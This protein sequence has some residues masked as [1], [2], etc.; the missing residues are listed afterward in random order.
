MVRGDLAAGLAVWIGAVLIVAGFASA[1]RAVAATGPAALT[2]LAADVINRDTNDKLPSAPTDIVSATVDSGAEGIVLSFRTQEMG[3]PATDPHWAS[4][5]TFVSWQIDSNGDGKVE[6]LIRYSADRAV[7]GGIAGDLTHWSGPGVPAKHCDAKAATFSAASGYTLTVDP[8]CLANPSSISYRVQLTYD[9]TPGAA[10]PP[11]AFDVAPDQGL[12]GPVPIAIPT[13]PA[14]AP[15]AGGAPAPAA[16][17][18]PTPAQAGA[19]TPSPAPKPA[20]KPAAKPAPKPATPAPTRGPAAA[21]SPTTPAPA[22]PSTGAKPGA[23]AATGT[24]TTRWLA[25]LGGAFVL[26]GGL[27]LM[28]DRRRRTA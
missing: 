5:N 24:S 10:K 17:P 2:D 7:P 15:P 11:L 6:D 23:L 25:A 9:T 1:S 21:P 20:A 26:L 19:P 16:G 18:A 28:T 8:A 27:A 22:A 13:A 14:V 4:P 3:D 12:A